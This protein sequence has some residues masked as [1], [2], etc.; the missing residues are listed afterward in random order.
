MGVDAL[1]A[2]YYP[3]FGGH[4]NLQIGAATDQAV[5]EEAKAEQRSQGAVLRDLIDE[6]LA[7]T[8]LP[9]SKPLSRRAQPRGRTFQV[10]AS[11]M[12]A[13]PMQPNKA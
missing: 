1:T 7:K 2:W 12:I 13:M 9:Q 5:A 3:E 11:R 10:N 6:H 4:G 8:A